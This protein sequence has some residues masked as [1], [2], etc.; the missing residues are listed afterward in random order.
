MSLKLS[1]LYGF[2]GRNSPR[3]EK[4]RDK[5]QRLEEQ[6]RDLFA[7]LFH[8][9]TDNAYLGHPA[10]VVEGD[11]NYKT[12]QTT[13]AFFPHRISKDGMSLTGIATLSVDIALTDFFREMH[14]IATNSPEA[15]TVEKSI[16]ED[17]ETAEIYGDEN[18][19]AI[20]S[21]SLNAANPVDMLRLAYDFMEK[22]N[23][24]SQDTPSAV[25]VENM[26]DAQ[27]AQLALNDDDYG[28]EV[29]LRIPFGVYA[30]PE[31]AVSAGIVDSSEGRFIAHSLQAIESLISDISLSGAKACR[32][33]SGDAPLPFLCQFH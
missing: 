31:A 19:Y 27:S 15:D 24:S 23:I 14:E 11:Y 33:D 32:K 13:V 18:G 10:L 22:H 28:P 12:G 17:G 25:D 29:L 26:L 3:P 16:P 21:Y 7:E 8:V 2:H 9:Y 6:L 30:S 20:I 1:K 4:I 5:I